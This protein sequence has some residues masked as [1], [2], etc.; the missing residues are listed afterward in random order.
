MIYP[1]ANNFGNARIT[2]FDQVNNQADTI[3]CVECKKISD[4]EDVVIVIRCNCHKSAKVCTT[5][6]FKNITELGKCSVCE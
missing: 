3:N 6:L 5:C 2:T 1:I 4:Q